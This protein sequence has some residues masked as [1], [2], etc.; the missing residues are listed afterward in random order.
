M[1][2]IA[3][4]IIKKAEEVAKPPLQ[5]NKKEEKNIKDVIKKSHPEYRPTK[6]GT[7]LIV[8]GKERKIGKKSQYLLDMLTLED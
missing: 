5:S 7:V 8:N 2:I 1:P 3:K 6:E 4:N